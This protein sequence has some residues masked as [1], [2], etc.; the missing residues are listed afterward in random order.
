MQY[1]VHTQAYISHGPWENPG[2]RLIDSCIPFICCLF[3]CFCFLMSPTSVKL[4][5]HVGLG[6]SICLSVGPSVCP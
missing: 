5:G 1:A 4:R 6:L 2:G 3:L